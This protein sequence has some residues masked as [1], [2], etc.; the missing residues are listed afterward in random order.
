MKRATKVIVGKK[1]GQKNKDG[2]ELRSFVFRISRL[3]QELFQKHP[4]LQFP[5]KCAYIYEGESLNILHRSH[6]FSVVKG[7]NSTL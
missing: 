3:D 7:N 6:K 5:E 4:E 1:K 2:M